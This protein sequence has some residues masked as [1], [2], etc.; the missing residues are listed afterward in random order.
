MGINV[1][2]I[3]ARRVKLKY[4]ETVKHFDR[5]PAINEITAVNG[6]R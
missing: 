3:L 4:K 6:M 5:I 1:L 2:K